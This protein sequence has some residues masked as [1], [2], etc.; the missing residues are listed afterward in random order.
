[1]ELY[2]YGMNGQYN[3]NFQCRSITRGKWSAH[4]SWSWKHEKNSHK[5]HNNL[6]KLNA[7]TSSIWV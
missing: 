2:F 6:T 3:A 4:G 1:M 7:M 5:S